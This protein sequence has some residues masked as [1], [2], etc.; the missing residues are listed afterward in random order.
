M[1]FVENARF[2]SLSYLPV[3][4]L[5]EYNFYK[6][7]CLTLLIEKFCF[8]NIVAFSS[9]SLKFLNFFNVKLIS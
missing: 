9:K 8:Q 5:F 2:L 4:I 7:R 1:F 3:H 6:F